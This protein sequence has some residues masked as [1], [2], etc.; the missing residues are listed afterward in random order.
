[1][2]HRIEKEQAEHW[3][4]IAM[5]LAKISG[6]ISECQ[7]ILLLKLDISNP[8]AKP[9]KAIDA[10]A[11]AASGQSY[12]FCPQTEWTGGDSSDPKNFKINLPHIAR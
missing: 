11:E 5:N 10:I 2:K 3:G 4:Q 7:L 8:E 1:M 9:L 6:L 12:M